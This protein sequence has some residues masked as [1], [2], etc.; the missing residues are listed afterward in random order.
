MESIRYLREM[1][2]FSHFAGLSFGIVKQ[3]ASLYNENRSI[4][5]GVFTTLGVIAIPILTSLGLIFTLVVAPFRAIINLYA[6][7]G[8]LDSLENDFET[9]KIL[10]SD[11][12]KKI[13]IFF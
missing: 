6:R 7:E 9:V 8:L 11:I 4:A 1:P 5:A 2:C 3:A 10:L 13:D 12:F